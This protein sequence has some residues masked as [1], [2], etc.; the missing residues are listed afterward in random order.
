MFMKKPSHRI[1]DYPPRFYEPET[2]EKEKRK[3]KLGF[4][5]QRKRIRKKKNP[6]IWGIYV[7]AVVYL[8]LKFSGLV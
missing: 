4:R 1:F 3:K 6:V 2:D 5:Y 8:Y 7:I